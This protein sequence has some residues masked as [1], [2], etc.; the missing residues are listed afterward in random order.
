MDTQTQDLRAT[1]LEKVLTWMKAKGYGKIKAKADGY[2]EPS[3]FTRSE[4]DRSFIPD[5]TAVRRNKK[6]YFEVAMKS[7]DMKRVIRKWKLLS[8]IA[9]MKNGKLFLFAPRGH[10][11][12]T[13]RIVKE[14]N[15][16]AEVISI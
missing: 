12:F 1:T 10:K 11:A 3:A 16:N 14:R 6:N 7:D 9:S 4:T 13:Q 15:L 5:A 8:T 2:E